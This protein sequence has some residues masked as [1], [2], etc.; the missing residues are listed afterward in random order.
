MI[1]NVLISLGSASPPPR[2]AATFCSY[3][4]IDVLEVFRN[5]GVAI[6]QN[7]ALIAHVRPWKIR[8]ICSPSVQRDLTIGEKKLVLTI[9]IGLRREGFDIVP[10]DLLGRISDYFHLNGKPEDDLAQGY[11]RALDDIL[12]RFPEQRASC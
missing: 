11:A 8:G 7:E 9:R 6:V 2:L 3:V 1:D 5:L 4:N 12:G 10:L